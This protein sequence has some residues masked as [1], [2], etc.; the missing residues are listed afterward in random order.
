MVGNLMS[1]AAT[2]QADYLSV[3]NRSTP[4]ITLYIIYALYNNY[5][6]H[7]IHTV[8]SHTHANTDSLRFHSE[9]LTSLLRALTNLKK[10]NLSFCFFSFFSSLESWFHFYFHKNV[11]DFL[12]KCTECFLFFFKLNT[13][14]RCMLILNFYD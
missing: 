6:T 2:Y 4:L 11:F 9:I 13:L 10:K 3:Q 5:Y 8:C 14:I 12:R 1:E 7:Y